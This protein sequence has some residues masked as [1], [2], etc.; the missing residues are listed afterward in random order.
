[1]KTTNKEAII[2]FDGICNL[3]NRSVLFILKRDLKKQFLFASLQSDASKKLLLQFNDGNSRLKS[4]VLIEDETVYIKSTAVL[5]ICRRLGL[6]WRMMYVFIFIPKGWRDFI[7]D[8]IAKHRY[9]WFGKKNTCT[10]SIDGY[11]NRFI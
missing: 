7:Y 11:K 1:M 3:C 9:D 8:T 2:L 6:F 4:I 5:R 10:M